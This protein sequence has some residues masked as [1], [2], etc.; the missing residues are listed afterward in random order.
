[1]MALNS[2][3]P[4]STISMRHLDFRGTLNIT[5][6]N[7]NIVYIQKKKKKQIPTNSRQWFHVSKPKCVD[8]WV[9]VH[10]CVFAVLLLVMAGD[11]FSGIDWLIDMILSLR[12]T[13]SSNGF[14]AMFD[15]I[16]DL[17]RFTKELWKW[18]CHHW[19]K[20]GFSKLPSGATRINRSELDIQTSALYLEWILR[21]RDAKWR[22]A[23]CFDET[24]NTV[25]QV[26]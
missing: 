11:T 3:H 17:R 20:N 25:Q 15:D 2:K 18:I 26:N 5:K 19:T 10:A 8:D 16:T 6:S 24:Q 9:H 14:S 4:K 21:F 7:I 22:S 13:F 12:D 23:L 1:M